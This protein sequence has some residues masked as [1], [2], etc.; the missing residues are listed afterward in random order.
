MTD[1][2]VRAHE[3]AIDVLKERNEVLEADRRLLGTKVAELE[4]RLMRAQRELDKIH[5][6]AA[7]LPNRRI[8]ACARRALSRLARAAARRRRPGSRAPGGGRKA[9]TAE[10]ASGSP[11]S[12]LSASDRTPPTPTPRRLR[13]LGVLDTMSAACFGEIIDLVLPDPETAP[14]IVRSGDFDLVLVESAWKGNAE[15]WQYHVGTYATPGHRGL[16]ALREL[17][18]AAERRGVPTAFWN[19]EDPVHFTRFAEAARIFDYVFTTDAHRIATYRALNGRAQGVEA[20]QFAAQPSL[21]NPLGGARR[22]VAPVFA[23]TFYQRRHVDRQDTL[24]ILL[25]AAAPYGLI[26]Y[27]RMYRSGQE[28]YAFPESVADR[29]VG[30]LPYTELVHAY[31]KHKVFLN[32]NSVTVSPTMFARRVFELLACGTAVVSTPSVGMRKIFGPLVDAVDSAAEAKE[33]LDRLLS[34]ESYWRQR[35]RDGIRSVM[36]H[37]TYAHRLA[38][39]ARAIGLPEPVAG[40]SVSLVCASHDEVRRAHRLLDEC[41]GIG[42][43]AVPSDTPG[44]EIE[45]FYRGGSPARRIVLFDTSSADPSRVMAEAAGRARS[46]WQI[47]AADV[48]EHDATMVTD[49]AVATVFTASAV[50]VARPGAS[51]DDLHTE[52]TPQS[53]DIVAR[54]TSDVARGREA[55]SPALVAWVEP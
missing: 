16:P 35:S 28:G 11:R 22:S 9:D 34:E 44:E 52:S 38:D 17:V 51:R 29:V 41:R 7:Q 21:H 46:A 53:G 14:E 45:R 33:A 3:A 39:V 36:L 49:L 18:A 32:A 15:T 25:E 5:A 30:S 4:S 47:R 37:H 54:R 24:R 26:I 48:L 6:S 27:D 31:R 20:L 50:V 43:V 10:R 13:V 42:E 23:G 55:G 19:K 2:R 12:S 40:P 8:G 1:A